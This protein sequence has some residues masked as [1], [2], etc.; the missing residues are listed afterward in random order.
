MGFVDLCLARASLGTIRRETRRANQEAQVLRPPSSRRAHRDE[1]DP[2][3]VGGALVLA[4]LL[5][6]T[7]PPAADT[8]YDDIATPEGWA[9]SQIKPGKVADFSQHSGLAQNSS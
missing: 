6:L 1:A 2:R 5:A 7:V 8:R 3:L 9:W 4:G